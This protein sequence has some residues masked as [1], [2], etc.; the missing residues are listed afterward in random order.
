MIG[1]KYLDKRNATIGAIR[2]YQTMKD[3][4][5]ITPAE[6]K[7]TYEKMVSPCSSRITGMP[8]VKNFRAGED[9]VVKSIDKL[10]VMQERYHQAAEYMA[11]FEPAW[12]SLSN[13]EQLILDEFYN[14]G[15]LHSGACVRLQHRLLYSERQI[16]RK[17]D[18]AINRL[19]HMLFGK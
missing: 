8:R 13:D 18:K 4:I 2:D 9:A 15:D 12:E 11:W 7:E 6:I 10:D 19:S 3:I 16:H 5:E 17:K 1:W 14:S